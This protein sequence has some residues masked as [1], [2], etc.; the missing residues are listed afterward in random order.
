MSKNIIHLHREK[1]AS[2]DQ[3]ECSKER[4]IIYKGGN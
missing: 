2:K 1:H 4:I 3:G